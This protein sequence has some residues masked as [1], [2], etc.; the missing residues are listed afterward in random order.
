[1]RVTYVLPHPELNGGN[2]V[3]FQ[4]ANLLRENGDEVTILGA[5][6]KPEWM[7]IRPAWIDYAATVPRLP[8]QDLVVATYWTTLRVARRLSLGPLA[9]FCQG[10]EG[11]LAH[12]RPVL[13]EIEEVYSWRVP[14]LTV[15]PHLGEL[16]RQRFGRESRVV[17][18]PLD[19]LFR[20]AWRLGP[21][22]RPWIAIP[23][24][25]EAEVKGIPV[26]L[27]AVRR[28]RA[29]GL[30]CRVLR[31][32]I[33]P[34][35]EAER[36]LLAP[37]RYL[38]GVPPAEIARALR[39]CDLLLLPS[40]AE[41]GFGLPLL[42]AMASKV[43]AVAT[44]IPST[45]FVTGGAVPLVEPSGLAD[46]ARELLTSRRAWR[47]ARERGYEAARRFRPEEVAPRLREG[48]RW[49]RELAVTAPDALPS[50]ALS[51]DPKWT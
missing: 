40:R 37:D 48:I 4:H 29:E 49:A 21:R 41:E 11:G 34:L 26:A 14:T 30:P 1:M 36:A 22:R 7:E 13:G 44:R 16:L 3:I 5:G 42:E 50:L 28:L 51:E 18:P 20:P 43:P 32:S 35:S 33:F 9:H 25:F 46:A 8:E 2:K 24:I 15:A 27:E 10:Y 23:G 12:L 38:H 47:R 6:P 17:P 39:A 19:P 45:P 31:F